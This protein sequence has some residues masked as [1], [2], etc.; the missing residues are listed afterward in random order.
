MSYPS[1]TTRPPGSGPIGCT[2]RPVRSDQARPSAYDHTL[3]ALGGATGAGNAGLAVN[4]VTR[5]TASIRP[6]SAAATTWLQLARATDQPLAPLPMGKPPSSAP[7]EAPT[8]TAPTLDT[9]EFL[10]GDRV[11]L[12]QRP[13][14]E[15]ARVTSIRRV[16]TGWE[17][18]ITTYGD[19][20][21]PG[22][23]V[24]IFTT[25]GHSTYLSRR[26]TADR[27]GR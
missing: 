6:T 16:A 11:L 2:A 7:W 17:Y 19:A 26:D 9:P 18:V 21:T 4:R 5:L 3:P 24:N 27:P 23:T 10:T 14:A 15:P 22:R 13:T 1:A 12:H 25:S 8:M 20:E